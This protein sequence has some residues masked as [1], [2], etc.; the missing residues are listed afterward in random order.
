MRD[1]TLHKEGIERSPLSVYALH[2]QQI[3]LAPK[4]SIYV[5]GEELSLDARRLTFVGKSQEKTLDFIM[6][7]PT[8]ADHPIE[9]SADEFNPGAFCFSP[10]KMPE[11]IWS[12][13]IKKAVMDGH[14]V[15]TRTK[16]HPVDSGSELVSVVRTTDFKM[17]GSLLLG[18]S[19]V[20]ETWMLGEMQEKPAVQKNR[21]AFTVGRFGLKRALGI[22]KV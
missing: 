19:E 2:S 4:A 12:T 6:V 16:D 10:D 8:V 13:I 15:R 22:N 20:Q 3:E 1:E 14:N 18:T 21:I 5:N 7:T 11:E 9:E 17:I